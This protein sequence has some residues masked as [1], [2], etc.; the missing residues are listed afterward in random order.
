MMEMELIYRL[1]MLVGFLSAGLLAMLIAAAILGLRHC[2][3]SAVK[4]LDRM[5]EDLEKMEEA[6][7][8]ESKQ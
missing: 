1:S 5:I 3:K 7:L 8:D 6:C 4:D 2:Y